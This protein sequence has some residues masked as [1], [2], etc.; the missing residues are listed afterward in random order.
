MSSR[1]GHCDEGPTMSANAGRATDAVQDKSLPGKIVILCCYLDGRTGT[2]YAMNG[3]R[4][5]LRVL[6]Q[7]G[8]NLA[9]TG[10]PHP[11]IEYGTS[12]TPSQLLHSFPSH[13][14]M[15]QPFT[16]RDSETNSVYHDLSVHF[17]C[18]ESFTSAAAH[19]SSSSR[20]D[21]SQPSFQ[22]SR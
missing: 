19:R 21:R 7:N 13:P 15:S 12:V 3:P 14:L 5:P 20:L 1:D 2:L 4:V 10:R 17:R 22:Y 18:I 16:M 6:Y 9:T 8:R 11:R